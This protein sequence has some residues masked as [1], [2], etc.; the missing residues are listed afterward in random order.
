MKS[1]VFFVSVLAIAAID[2]TVVIANE[3]YDLAI[4][5]PKLQDIS[6]TKLVDY[7]CDRSGFFNPQACTDSVQRC[8]DR[9]QFP[10]TVTTEM[11]LDVMNGCLNRYIR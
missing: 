7:T 5:D 4:K 1:T 3:I 8:Y 9:F 2:S 6:V 10:K 11:K